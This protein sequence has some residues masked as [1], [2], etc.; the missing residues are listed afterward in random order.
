MVS[1]PLL[2]HA[3]RN[4]RMQ[5]A[6]VLSLHAHEPHN[7]RCRGVSTVSIEPSFEIV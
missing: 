1:S 5:G 7:G 6:D 4:K 3:G 2:P